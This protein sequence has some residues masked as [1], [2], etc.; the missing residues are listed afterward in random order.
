[1]IMKYTQTKFQAFSLVI[2]RDI[3][4]KKMLAKNR[5]LQFLALSHYDTSDYFNMIYII[6]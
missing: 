3:H 6:G 5:N 1:M 4:V 2:R